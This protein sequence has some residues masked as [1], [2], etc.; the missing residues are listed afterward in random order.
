MGAT[1]PV[2]GGGGGGGQLPWPRF[3]MGGAGGIL[4]ALMLRVSCELA[5]LM[6]PKLATRLRR[7]GDAG[8]VQLCGVCVC[9]RGGGAC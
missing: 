1:G 4:G 6:E 3:T 2:G 8:I 9:G 5:E 7:A